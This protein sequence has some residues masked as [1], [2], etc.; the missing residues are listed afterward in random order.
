MSILKL[1][2]AY[3][4]NWTTL[5][6]NHLFRLHVVQKLDE[7]R[8]R[9][10]TVTVHLIEE[11]LQK[12][13]TFTEAVAGVPT[14]LLAVHW[15]WI[16]LSSVPG[17]LTFTIV[18]DGDTER[19][20]EL[21]ILVHVMRSLGSRATRANFME[22]PATIISTRFTFWDIGTGI[23]TH[24][25]WPHF[26]ARANNSLWWNVYFAV[27]SETKQVISCMLKLFCSSFHKHSLFSSIL[28]YAISQ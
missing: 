14:P 11:Y 1:L 28:N 25:I 22:L 6:R 10:K 3:R 2:H 5:S 4:A 8:G 24:S 23:S 13:V 27:L 17:L 7:F 15:Y 18:C 26:S 19:T 9:Q 21:P 20:L 12:T 16:M